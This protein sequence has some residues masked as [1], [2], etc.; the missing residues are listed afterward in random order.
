MFGIGRFRAR[1][2]RSVR[3]PDQHEEKRPDPAAPAPPGRGAADPS[4]ARELRSLFTVRT[5]AGQVFCLVLALVLLLVV[6]GAVA[7]VVQGRRDSLDEARMR[8]LSVAQTFA[9]APGIVTALDGKDPTAILQPRAEEVR[10]DAHVDSVVV[11]STQGIRYTHPNPALIGKHLIGPYKEALTGPGFTRTFKGSQGLSVTSVVPVIRP[12]GS[13]AGLVSVG[14][15]NE[16]VS[17]VTDRYIPLAT[18]V[19]LI[20]AALTTTGA[21]LLSRRLR[22]QTHG[23]GPA[24]MTRMYEHHDAVLHAVREG[25]LIVGADQRLTLVND[26]ARRLLDLPPDAEGRAVT[27]LGLPPDAAALLTGGDIVTDQVLRSGKRLLAVNVRHTDMRRGP[28]GT[29][30]TLRDTT[31]LSAVTGRASLIRERLLLL[32]E[33]GA[34]VGTTLDVTRTAQE[35]ADVATPGFADVT[36]VDLA[37]PAPPGEE[38]AADVPLNMH[39]T[40]VASTDPEQPLYPVGHQVGL[41]PTRT[42]AM[43]LDVAETGLGPDVIARL[44]WQNWN[45][46]R[47]EDLRLFGFRAVLSVPLRARGVTLGLANFWRFRGAEPFDGDDESFAEEL[48]ARAAVSI[49]N[50]RRYTREH[51]MAVTLQRSLLPRGLPEQTALEVAHRYLPARAEVGGD[52]FDVIPLPGA[53]VALVVGDVIGHGLHAAANMGRLR[54]SIHNFSALDLAPDELLGHL[55]EVVSRIDR[56]EAAGESGVE[57]SGATCLY[58]IYDAVS[59]NCTMARAG[60]PGP[61]LILPDGTVEFPEGPVGLPLGIGGMPFESAEFHV[62]EGSRLVLFTDGLFERR[63]RDIDAGLEMLRDA[64][65]GRDRTPEETCDAAL[66]AMLPDPPTDDVALLVART[67][68]LDPDQVAQWDVATDPAAVAGVRRNVAAWLSERGLD[69]E[70]FTTELILSELVTNAM[71]YGT[72]PIEVRLLYDRSL[73]CEVSDTSNTSPHLRYAATTDEGGRGLFLVAQIAERWGT[74]YTEAGKVIWS[75]QAV[76]EQ[77]A[78]EGPAERAGNDTGA[79]DGERGEPDSGGGTGPR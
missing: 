18:A 32:Y 68:I 59:G 51:E 36:T 77:G 39:R 55:D 35:L 37:T 79:A 65:A 44:G 13:V 78:A 73:I 75:E 40:A 7:L 61:A 17:S 26:E 21:A 27:D 16:S 70:A 60:H 56:A 48:V 12:D 50:A 53:R 15:T 38:P 6:A 25:V 64:L 66:D 63:G 2:R 9:S 14:L 46:E 76:G 57:I 41:L 11:A 74:R 54:T 71:R 28:P 22:R 43:R 1:L 33:A 42:A 20:A 52:W 67:R 29:V 62:P 31:E 3:R 5:V 72:G 34:R 69:E 30:V 47:A 8:T 23:L 4:P 24:E 19:A 45:P 49:D 10:R 58:A